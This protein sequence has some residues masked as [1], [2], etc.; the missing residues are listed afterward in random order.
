MSGIA[1]LALIRDHATT[2]RWPSPALDP[3]LL[4]MADMYRSDLEVLNY[5]EVRYLLASSLGDANRVSYWY[6]RALRANHD[7]LVTD[8]RQWLKALGDETRAGLINHLAHVKDEKLVSIYSEYVNNHRPAQRTAAIRALDYLNTVEAQGVLQNQL[9]YDC[10][11]P[12]GRFLRGSNDAYVDEAPETEIALN[13]YYIS[14]YPVTNGDYLRYLNC[15]VE[16]EP[17]AHWR[18]QSIEQIADHPVVWI[19]WHDAQRYA[20]WAGQRLPSEA[21]WEKAA[22]G[23]RG[24]RWPWGNEFA[25]GHCNT[26]ES[27]THG[28]AAVTRYDSTNRSAYGVV[29]MAGNVWEWVDDWYVPTYPPHDRVPHDGESRTTLK[30]LRGGSWR[31]GFD[32]AR[33]AFRNNFAPIVRS[34]DIGFRT[35]FSPLLVVE[36]QPCP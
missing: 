26:R 18:M 9:V 20:L 22:R 21:E 34:D 28:T 6:G 25:P 15:A 14:K 17:P 32:E 27:G 16:A 11:I 24:A 10:Q 13:R 30:V 5:G 4:A 23:N 1:L 19:N 31:F 2:W 7:A 3:H 36:S 8:I 12:S 29:D 35:A 33:C